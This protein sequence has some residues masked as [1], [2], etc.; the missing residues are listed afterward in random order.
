MRPIDKHQ[1]GRAA[2]D[3]GTTCDTKSATSRTD[4]S[5]FHEIEDPICADIFLVGYKAWNG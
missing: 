2:M 5:I 4:Q 1:M 3:A